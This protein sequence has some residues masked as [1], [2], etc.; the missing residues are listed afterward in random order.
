V[1]LGLFFITVGMLLNWRLV[2]EHLWLVLLLFIVPMVIKLLL[3]AGLAKLLAIRPVFLCAPVWRW[4]R[5]VS[6]VLFY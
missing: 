5:R 2:V 4:R 1:L 3:I 6:L